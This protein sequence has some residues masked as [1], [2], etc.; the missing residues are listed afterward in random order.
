MNDSNGAA[1]VT[2]IQVHTGI[3]KDF[4]DWHA[5]MSIAPGGFPGFIGTEVKAPAGPEE[6]EW[7]VVQHFRSVDEMR[8][9]QRSDVHQHLLNQIGAIAGSNALRE[10]ENGEVDSDSSVT[11]VIATIVKPGL[12]NSYREWAEKIHAVEAQFPGYRGGLL[13]PPVSEKQP[14][15]TTLVRFATPHELDNWLNSAERKKLLGEHEGIV[16]S[17]H[18]RRLPNSF[19]GWFPSEDPD[20]ESPTTLKQSLVVLLVL[21]PIVMAEL[22]F[23]APLLSRLPPAPATFVG[24]AISVGLI[25]W[26]LMP[27]AVVFL[28]W[29]LS[30]RPGATSA[31][32]AAGYALIAALYV[33]EIAA[34]WN[35]V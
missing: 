17:W 8:A 2:R 4:A 33:A 35:L 18:M 6:N 23:L 24:N 3:E 15:W 21:F 1:L 12:E 22:R 13:Q 27:L 19:A 25:G 32:R 31:Q 20:R 10:L 29:W 7:S 11:E 9:W 5:R 16:R 26:P 14:Y 28:N 34:L 30:P